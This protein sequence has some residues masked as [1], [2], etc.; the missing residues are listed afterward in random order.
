MY[1]ENIETKGVGRKWS[2]SELIDSYYTIID[3]KT[4]ESIK[5]LGVDS[6]Y[7]LRPLYQYGLDRTGE[8]IA[9]ECILIG[10]ESIKKTNA[11][12]FVAGISILRF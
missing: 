4:I 7:L 9:K 12:P 3:E 8:L 10:K 5:N 2:T 11:V 1:V 6:R